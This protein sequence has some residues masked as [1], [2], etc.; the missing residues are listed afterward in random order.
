MAAGRT[1]VFETCLARYNP[2]IKAPR[3]SSNAPTPALAGLRLLG[4]WMRGVGRRWPALTG[5]RPGT[6]LKL[7]SAPRGRRL[8]KET[9]SKQK[10]KKGVEQEKKEASV[11]RIQNLQ[12]ISPLLRAALGWIFCQPS[13]PGIR[14]PLTPSKHMAFRW[15]CHRRHSAGRLENGFSFSH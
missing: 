7:S 15:V 13:R 9:T 14:P 6:S 12:R 5:D 10:R 1:R 11:A 4:Y 3:G 2:F 8:F